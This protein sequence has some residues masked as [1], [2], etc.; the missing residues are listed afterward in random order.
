VKP[1]KLNSGPGHFSHILT[2]EDEENL[3]ENL[4]D[5]HLFAVQMVDYYFKNIV[6]FL[7]T[8]VAPLDFTY[9]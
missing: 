8:R 3:D 4:P 6:H 5:V 9:A 1:G 2:G 7:S